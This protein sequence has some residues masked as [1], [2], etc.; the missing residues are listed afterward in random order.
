MLLAV[1]L[2]VFVLYVLGLVVFKITAAIIHLA[3]FVAVLALIAHFVR[4][5]APV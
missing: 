2:V 4:K 1:A 3:L 5:R